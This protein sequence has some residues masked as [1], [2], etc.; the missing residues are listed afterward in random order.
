MSIDL[1]SELLTRES[2]ARLYKTHVKD[3]IVYARSLL[4]NHDDAQE[5]VHDLFCALYDKAPEGDIQVSSIRA[6]LFASVKN[7]AFNVMKKKKRITGLRDNHESSVNMTESV[8]N[9]ISV[10]E[11]YAYI[12]AVFPPDKREI[13]VLRVIHGLIWREIAD[14]T[15]RPLSTVHMVFNEGVAV[16]RERFPDVL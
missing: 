8:H 4:N 15:G 3:L 16:L 6:F 5:V 7:R 13:F 14:V 12:H 10:R 1:K 11:I 2:I 9:T